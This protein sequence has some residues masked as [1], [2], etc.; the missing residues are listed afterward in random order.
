MES[1]GCLCVF[2][3]KAN[4]D[5]NGGARGRWEEN[6]ESDEMQRALSP[7]KLLF[8]PAGRMNCTPPRVLLE[9]QPQLHAGMTCSVLVPHPPPTHTTSWADD[10]ESG[11]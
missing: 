9:H 11:L 6:K 3:F 4:K 1:E 7:E 10:S 8:C 2:V 5:D